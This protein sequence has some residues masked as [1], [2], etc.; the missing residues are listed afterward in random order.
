MDRPEPGLKLVSGVEV[1][2][3]YQV[4]LWESFSYL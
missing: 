4:K 3:Q 2:E 1:E